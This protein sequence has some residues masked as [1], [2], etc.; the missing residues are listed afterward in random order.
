MRELLQTT[1]AQVVIGFT[2]LLILTMIGTYVVLRFRDIAEDDE[3]SSDLLMKFREMRHEGY[4]N[5]A[6]YRTIRTDLES[7][8]SEQSSAKSSDVTEKRDY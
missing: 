5:E 3:T 7:K 4:L 1:T 8:L 6:E 2:G